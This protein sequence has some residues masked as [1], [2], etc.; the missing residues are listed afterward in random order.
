MLLDRL[1]DM[2]YEELE[3]LARDIREKIVR[4]VL[5]NG[6]HLASNLGTVELTIAL[7]RVFDP[8]RDVIVWDTGH[9]C[10]T[11]K[12]LTGR[13]KDFHNLRKFGGISGFPT[14]K[15][16]PLDWFGTGHSGTS[17]AAALGFEKAFALLGEARSV[18]VVIGDGAL[19][20]G[21]ALEALNQVK[22]LNSKIKI[23]LN[24]NEMSISKNVGGIAYHLSML[25]TN[26]VYLKG[27][28]LLKKI[29]EKTDVGMEIEEEM[30]SWRNGLKGIVQGV[31]VF[32]SLGIKYFG[33]F[34]GHNIKLLENVF[35]RIKDYDY[36][37]LVHVV[38]KKGKGFPPAEEDP[39]SYH[40]VTVGNAGRHT[41]SELFGRVLVRMAEEDERIV[42]VTAAMEDGTGLKPFKERF[43]KRFFDLGITEQTCVT[44]GAALGLAGFKPV[45]AVY[46]SF[47]QRA[48]DQIVH[49]V[50]LQRAPVLLA[51]DRAGVVGEDGPTHHGLF[52]LNFL[53]SI[54]NIRI[55]SPSSPQ[56]FAD[57]IYTVLRNLE[58]PT[59]VRYPREYFEDDIETVL[60]NMKEISLRWNIVRRGKGVA[61]VSVGTLLREVLSV[62]EILGED[63]SVVSA[64]Q[65]K[66]VDREELRWL[67]EEHNLVFTVE[68]S[69]KIGGFGSYLGQLLSEMGWKGRIVNVGVEDHFVPQGNREE[70]LK[71]LGLDAKG[72]FEV[73]SAY[74]PRE[75]TRRG[76]HEDQPRG[77]RS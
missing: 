2:S 35:K 53:L 21:E 10:Y 77:W 76:K 63:I 4:V 26:S 17:I 46:S 19:T 22:N 43:P 47:L 39:V 8:R 44:F 13:D 73:V 14:P 27:K 74:F 34:D 50:A 40:S 55:L 15:E 48:Y 49:D 58:G 61:L 38:T 20:S 71:V 12:I 5:E 9:Q 18:V 25:R 16:S 7:Y 29:L 56:E 54:P 45:V 67:A 24:D 11:H 75:K 28:E 6:G 37:V 41:Y 59:V 69:T 31:N 60:Q 62:V 3:V 52:D 30:R 32:E 65:V 72:L 70:L 51:V 68:E 1:K 36:P 64:L 23:V 57:T 42:A 33:P 66:P